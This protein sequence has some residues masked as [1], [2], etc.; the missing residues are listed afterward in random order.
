MASQPILKE[1]MSVCINYTN[2]A[3]NATIYSMLWK[4]LAEN[5]EQLGS[6]EQ[7]EGHEDLGEGSEKS[8]RDD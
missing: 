3:R 1:S 6:Q 8:H 7:I 2:A 4:L 5:F